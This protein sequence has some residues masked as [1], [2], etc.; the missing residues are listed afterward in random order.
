MTVQLPCTAT[1][2]HGVSHNYTIIV[3]VVNTDI[4]LLLGM[5]T[6]EYLNICTEPLES[7]CK[8]GHGR[9]R[10]KYELITTESGHWAVKLDKPRPKVLQSGDRCYARCYANCT[11]DTNGKTDGVAWKNARVVETN[12]DGTVLIIYTD[13]GNMYNV[14]I[15]DIV[16]EES[17]IPVIEGE[18]IDDI[19]YSTDIIDNSKNEK[20]TGG[21]ET[22]LFF[23]NITVENNMEFSQ[24]SMNDQI[25]PEHSNE[26]INI[27]EISTESQKAVVPSQVEYNLTDKPKCEYPALTP[28]RR[29]CKSDTGLQPNRPLHPDTHTTRSPPESNNRQLH[30]TPTEPTVCAKQGCGP[31]T[32]F[33]Q[34]R[35]YWRQQQQASTPAHSYKVWWRR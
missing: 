2:I 35:K 33:Q 23:A 20:I 11:W 10:Y 7:T 15:E 6:H 16:T 3:H 31:L 17:D 13:Y 22:T 21:D 26:A 28:D 5:D 25:P 18:V 12:E 27:T 34:A 30:Y 24:V 14:D 8:I 9:D 32:W 19:I 4:P 1:D 29:Q